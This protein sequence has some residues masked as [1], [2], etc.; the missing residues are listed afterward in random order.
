MKMLD[1][2]YVNSIACQNME[3]VLDNLGIEYRME[4]GW[5]TTRCM[6]HN[7]EHFNLKFRGNSFYCFS[8]CR[9]QYNIFEITMKIRECSFVEA[10]LWLSEILGINPDE[11]EK[12]NNGDNKHVKIVGKLVELKSKKKIEYKQVDEFT[13]SSIQDMIHPWMSKQGFSIKT[14][15]HFGIGYG[16]HGVLNGRITFPIDAPNGQIISVSGRMPDYEKLEVPKYYI[17]GHSQVKNTLWNYSRIDKNPSE[18]FVVEG[19]KSVMMLYQHGYKNSVAAIGASLSREQKNLLLKLACN[20]TVICDNDQVG[21]QFGQ[22]VYNQCHLF[23]NVRV[24]KLSYIT[25]KPKA[26][27]DDLD[28]EEWKELNKEIG[29][30]LY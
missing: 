26:S 22:A 11:I 15:Q 27:V 29:N 3:D 25:D 30:D 14:C 7:G 6:F 18:V 19:F 17:I 21:E 1:S 28:F 8:Q 20:I 16:I 12:D 5:I 10:I 9:R 4:N 23:T 13:L 24:I 2:D